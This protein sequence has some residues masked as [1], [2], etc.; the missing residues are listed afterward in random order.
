MSNYELITKIIESWNIAQY[1]YEWYYTLFST[2]RSDWDI[3]ASYDSMCLTHC[4]DSLWSMI[5]NEGTINALLWTISVYHKP[6]PK[7]YKAWD[8]IQ[9][10]PCVKDLEWWDDRKYGAKEIIGWPFE[11]RWS[12]SVW[13][14]IYNKNKTDSFPFPHTVL[15]PRIE[16]AVDPE[17]L[18][19]QE[20]I[21]RLES[22][23]KIKDGKILVS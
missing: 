18:L 15:A 23:G 11:I 20:A 1:E 5:V 4:Y 22:R 17:D 7:P 10:L 16:P 19:D 8:L 3:R 2:I 6:P 14:A 9:I 21:K 13:Y 12:W